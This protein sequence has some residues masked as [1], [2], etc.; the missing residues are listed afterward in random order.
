VP[1][2]DDAEPQLLALAVDEVAKQGDVAVLEDL[3]GQPHPGHQGAAQREERE[4]R[5][6]R[7]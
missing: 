7:L 3:E 1:D 2:G 4:G 5:H 6:T